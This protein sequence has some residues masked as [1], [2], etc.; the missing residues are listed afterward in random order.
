[1]KFKF[2]RVVATI[3][4]V[5]LSVM[6]FV[7]N[8]PKSEAAVQSDVITK[9]EITDENDNPLTGEVKK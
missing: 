5:L 9:F 1:M 3:L 8:A 7:S 4:V 6:T 2:N